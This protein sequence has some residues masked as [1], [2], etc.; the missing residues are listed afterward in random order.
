M[1]STAPIHRYAERFAA[2]LARGRAPA[3]TDEI[4]AYLEGEPQGVFESLEGL[5]ER[6]ADEGGDEQMVVAYMTLLT[7]QLEFLRYQV[8]RGYQKAIDLCAAFEARVAELVKGGELPEL[9][10]GA[11]G[12][13]MHQAKLDPGPTLRALQEQALDA[14][15]AEQ[16]A[17]L[18]VGAALSEVAERCGGDVF[19]LLESM[20]KAMHVMPPAARPL[21]AEQMLKSPL[22]LLR[23]G[24]ALVTLD[25]DKGVRHAAMAT[26]LGSAGALTPTALR[27]LIAIRSW[28]PTDEHPLLDQVVRAARAVGVECAPWKPGAV[29]SLRISSIDGSGAQGALMVS[30]AAG[31]FRCSSLLFR[32]GIGIIDAWVTEPMAKGR[33]RQMLRDGEEGAALR[34]V[35][36]SLL[37]QMV[38]HHL[39]TGLERGAPP[40]V[41]LLQVA[42]TIA[43][44]EWRPACLDWRASLDALLSEVP[45]ALRTQARLGELANTSADWAA[46][47]GLADSWFEDDQE[48][49]DLLA[50]VPR[51]RT[52]KDLEYV[53]ATIIERRKLKWAERFVWTA[54]WLKENTPAPGR[55]WSHFALIAHEIVRGRS[56]DSIAVMRLIARNT[57]MTHEITDGS[58]LDLSSTVLL[59]E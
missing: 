35:T 50:K 13:A 2:S 9:A 42:E 49:A 48:V 34:Q 23:E 20:A 44:T 11:I 21:I 10:L 8:D 47:D 41:A 17:D 33:L 59:C 14:G 32:F 54:L 1:A 15:Q 58:G 45:P 52:E 28:L 7:M 36:R 6:L 55:L 29:T 31:K 25:P 24:A 18:D 12:M 46:A 4:A 37:D 40:P 19:E 39:A 27:R 53:L 38:S 57:L 16:N 5:T 43:A 3:L 26:L 56:L 22:P 51:R 30:P